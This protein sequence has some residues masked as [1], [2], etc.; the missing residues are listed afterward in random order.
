ME[1]LGS[2]VGLAA[3]VGVYA[4]LGQT[5]LALILSYALIAIVLVAGLI[6]SAKAIDE[7]PVQQAPARRSPAS[8]AAILSGVAFLLSL[9]CI[10]A[11]LAAPLGSALI[12]VALIALATAATAAPAGRHVPALGRLFS[13]FKHKDFFWGFATHALATVG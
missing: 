10:F 3:V 5:R 6:V 4:L 1:Q 13:P 9:A 12:P 2:V 8:P 7:T 11:L